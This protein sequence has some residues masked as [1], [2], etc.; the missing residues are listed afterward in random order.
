MKNL[1]INMEKHALSFSSDGLIQIDGFSGN[2]PSSLCCFQVSECEHFADYGISKGGLLLAS[3]GASP[4][5]N[6]LV[7]TRNT[8]GPGVR[9][10]IYQRTHKPSRGKQYP[11]ATDE[12]QILGVI[13][14]A[15]SFYR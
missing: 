9:V 5:E 6:D 15:L 13:L 4:R 12:D 2:D 1:G 3:L 11:I 10:K 7:V 8:D 14:S